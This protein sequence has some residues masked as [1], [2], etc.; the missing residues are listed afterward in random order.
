MKPSSLFALFILLVIHGQLLAVETP[1]MD[2]LRESYKAAIKKATQPIHQTYLSELAKLRDGYTRD[3]KLE[4]AAKVQKE[5]DAITAEL[6]APA[7]PVALPSVRKAE[8]I[9]VAIP[10]NKVTGHTIGPVK[11]G[12]VIILSYVSGQWKDHG[13]SATENPDAVVIQTGESCR[14]VIANGPYKTQPGPV[15]ALVPAGSSV[16]PFSYTF[17]EDVENVVLRINEDSRDYESNPGAVTYKLR[18]YK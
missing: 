3:A 8:E 13:I 12:T 18:L 17:L 1:G 16:T 4:E 11:K 2:R 7:P 6:A 5:I 14:L 10:A 15:L 9:L